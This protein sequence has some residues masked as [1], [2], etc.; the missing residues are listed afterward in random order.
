MLPTGFEVVV[1]VVLLLA[2]AGYAAGV[3]ASRGRGRWPVHRTVCWG[4]GLLCVAAGTVGPLARAAHHS[5]TAHA[6]AHL[7]LAMVAPLLLV[8]AAPV[9]L[10]LRALPVRRAR[11]LSR[12]LRWPPV[13]VVSHPVVAAVLNAGGLWVLYRTDVFALTH[14]SAPVHVLVHAHLFLAGYL[15]TASVAGRDPDPHRASLPVRFGVLVVFVAVHSVL[16]K[17]LYADPPAGVAVADAERGAQ[18][19]YYGGDVVDLALMVLVVAGWY[20]ARWARPGP[21]TAVPAPAP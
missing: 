17:S 13:R 9:T 15:F 14:T 5:F 18:L 19:M 2:A 6:G 20:R 16:T 10:A 12:V 3:R 8:L 4:A 7:A 21:A 1:V 11:V